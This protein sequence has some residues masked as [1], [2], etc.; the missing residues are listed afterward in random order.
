MNKATIIGRI[1]T[2]TKRI[3]IAPTAVNRKA[4]LDDIVLS[5][6]QF[7]RM[8]WNHNG[9]RLT[10]HDVTVMVNEVLKV[11]GLVAKIRQGLRAQFGRR[12]AVQ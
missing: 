6:G 3:M 10:G 12:E 8:V 7:H 5:D 4:Q 2:E 11:D 1:D 9:Q